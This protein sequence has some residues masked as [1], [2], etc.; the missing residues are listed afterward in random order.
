MRTCDTN[1]FT[2]LFANKERVFAE[3]NVSC[4]LQLVASVGRYVELDDVVNHQ[5]VIADLVTI[6]E[7]NLDRSAR[8]TRIQ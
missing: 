8:Q 3:C 1:L 4:T 5:C 2:L 7:R 6:T